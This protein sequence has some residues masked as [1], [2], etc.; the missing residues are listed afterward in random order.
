MSGASI[1]VGGETITSGSE[2][3]LLDMQQAASLV[4]ITVP[5]LSKQKHHQVSSSGVSG[6]V[7]SIIGIVL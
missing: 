6:L 1:T 7:T 5:R 2:G 4:K 3:E